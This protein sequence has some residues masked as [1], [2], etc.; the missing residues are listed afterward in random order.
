MG[1]SDRY[2]STPP[3]RG[4]RRFA[5]HTDDVLFDTTSSSPSSLKDMT[6]PRGR[7]RSRSFSSPSMMRLFTHE[8]PSR[9]PLTMRSW[10]VFD[11]ATEIFEPVT[12]AASLLDRQ[13]D[14]SAETATLMIILKVERSTP[15]ALSRQN[16]RI[17]L[18]ITTALWRTWFRWNHGVV[19]R[20]STRSCLG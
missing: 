11:A 4:P 1:R 15:T 19:N 18:M 12:D 9:R 17:R 10:G 14:L 2:G 5:E 6:L 20:V 3:R 13:P 8:H 7:T 16:Q